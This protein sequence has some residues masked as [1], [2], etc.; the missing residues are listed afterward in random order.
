MC[1]AKAFQG[2]STFLLLPLGEKKKDVR[3]NDSTLIVP[4]LPGPTDQGKLLLNKLLFLLISVAIPDSLSTNKTC[5]L[6]YTQACVAMYDSFVYTDPQSK[7]T[8]HRQLNISSLLN[9]FNCLPGQNYPP[10]CGNIQLFQ[11]YYRHQVF[12]KKEAR[13]VIVNKTSLSRREQTHRQLAAEQSLET[14]LRGQ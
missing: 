3:L 8:V 11:S 1:S 2:P 5:P 14:A 10:L 7:P 9:T 13:H 12:S 6:E 4:R